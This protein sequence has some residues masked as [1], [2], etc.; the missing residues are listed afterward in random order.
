ARLAGPLGPGRPGCRGRVGGRHVLAEWATMV[1]E[2]MASTPFQPFTFLSWE[3]LEPR[4]SGLH[5]QVFLVRHR[6]TGDHFALK[7]TS[8]AD[9]GHA[10]KARRSLSTA[11]ANY[12][13]RHANVVTVHDLG[14]EE[15]GRVWILM[16]WLQGHSIAELLA[17]QRGQVSVPM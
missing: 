7:R 17:R 14:C 2:T 12:R 10:S 11:K 4:G 13:I 6:P 15:D 8:L 5:G 16:E 1:I 9:A 3:V